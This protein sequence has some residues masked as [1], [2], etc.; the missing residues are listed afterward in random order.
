[1]MDIII[2]SELGEGGY[3]V[4]QC[5]GAAKDLQGGCGREGE[6]EGAGEEIMSGNHRDIVPARE[7]SGGRDLQST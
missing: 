5:D 3:G 7:R 1:M 6:E 4:Q 2:G